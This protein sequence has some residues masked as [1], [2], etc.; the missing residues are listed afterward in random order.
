MAN[1][2]YLLRALDENGFFVSV[3]FC[4]VQAVAQD[5][6]RLRQCEQENQ[7]QHD[8]HLEVNPEGGGE[9]APD[10]LI[11]CLQCEIECLLAENDYFTARFSQIYGWRESIVPEVAGG[12]E[13]A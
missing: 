2:A 5:Q 3:A 11:E 7:R 8:P 6:R 9:I 10:R 13:T 4:F 12:G 1:A